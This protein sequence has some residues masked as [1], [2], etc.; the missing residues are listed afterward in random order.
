MKK[1]VFFKGMNLNDKQKK[2][3]NERVDI[4]ENLEVSKID[5][6]FETKKEKFEVKLNLVYDGKNISIQKTSNNID[7]ALNNAIDIGV[8]QIEKINLKKSSKGNKFKKENSNFEIEALNFNK[9]LK[10]EQI[11]SP[12]PI[13]IDLLVKDSNKNEKILTLDFENACIQLEL[14]GYDTYFYKDSSSQ[15]NM[16]VY[17]NNNEYFSK[18]V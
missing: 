10:K 5:I 13:V 1:K 18:I 12:E 7:I 14:L 4:F 2:V 15:K 8:D 9:F 17:K 11:E 16:V 3:L 6:V